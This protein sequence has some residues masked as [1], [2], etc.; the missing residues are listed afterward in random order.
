MSP[1]PLGR[2]DR[3]TNAVG[4]DG[5]GSNPG[6]GFT[7][8]P[9]KLGMNAALSSPLP[10]GPTVGATA[11]PKAGVTTAAASVNTKEKFRHC[12][13][14]AFLLLLLRSAVSS[15]MRLHPLRVRLE[16]GGVGLSVRPLAR[17][18][19]AHHVRQTARMTRYGLAAISGPRDLGPRLTGSIAITRD[20]LRRRLFLC[21]ATRHLDVHEH[22]VASD[23]QIDDA[24]NAA[25]A[26]AE[27][28][29]RQLPQLKGCSDNGEN[30][31][32]SQTEPDDVNLSDQSG[33]CDQPALLG[34]PFSPVVG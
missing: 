3:L 27:A 31:R 16:G 13:S 1:V 29:G 32:S 28:H 18:R 23:D 2:R 15:R 17:T 22:A 21:H 19:R 30:Q 34:N 11:W 6:S 25:A 4:P 24:R 9:P 10:A 20:E 8:R 12:E 33:V 7:Q 26:G 14:I 5:S